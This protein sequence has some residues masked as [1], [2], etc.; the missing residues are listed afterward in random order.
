MH[1][2]FSAEPNTAILSGFIKG[3]GSL[4]ALDA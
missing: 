3:A 4:M 1:Q 2:Q